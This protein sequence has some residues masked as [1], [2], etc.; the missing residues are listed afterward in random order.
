MNANGEPRGA[1]LARLYGKVGSDQSPKG[2]TLRDDDPVRC[3]IRSVGLKSAW[4]ADSEM[5]HT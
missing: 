1:A 4:Q 3:S 2:T 5:A